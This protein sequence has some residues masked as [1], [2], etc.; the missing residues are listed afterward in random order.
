MDYNIFRKMFCLEIWSNK[1]DWLK[2]EKRSCGVGRGDTRQGREWECQ[3]IKV[4]GGKGG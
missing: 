2:A 1:L 4:G 3:R